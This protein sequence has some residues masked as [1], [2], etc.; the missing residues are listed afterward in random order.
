MDFNAAHIHLMVNHL[1]ILA[2]LF[3][4]PILV[5][6]IIANQQAIKKVALVGFIVAGLTAIVAVQSGESAEDIAESVPGVTEQA[7]H[8]HEEAAET[9][10]WLAIILA[11]GAVTGYYLINKQN[12]YSKHVIW[13]L[14]I[15]SLVVG[16]M[17][18]YTA[19]LGGNITHHELAGD[20]APSEGL[21]VEDDD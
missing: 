8:D 3:S 21:N 13:G 20:G 2:T 15:Y 12:K 16:S 17:F 4:I 1:P 6:G 10:Q 18:I 11:V 9:T 7:I 19:Y 5:W 14:L